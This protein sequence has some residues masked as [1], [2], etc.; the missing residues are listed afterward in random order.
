MSQENPQNI[1]RSWNQ[2]QSFNT[3]P[4]IED[5]L[6]PVDYG[7]IRTLFTHTWREEKLSANLDWDSQA[8]SVYLPESLNVVSSVFLKI[9]LPA[10]G[11]DT[12]KKYP[13]IFALKPLRILSNGVEL[14]TVDCNLFFHDYLE[15][16]SEEGLH[17]VTEAYFG[18]TSA[19]SLEARTIMVPIML[20]NSQYL[21]RTGDNKGHGIFPCFLGN[22]TLELQLTLTP[23]KYV[24]STA[25]SVPASISGACS[26][27]YHQVELSESVLSTYSDLR[28]NY[29]IVNRRFTELTS[30]WTEY[31]TP[32][33]KANINQYQPQGAI[34]EIMVIAVPE[35]TDDSR[36]GTD[37]ILPTSIKVTTDS[38]V[39]KDLNTPNKVKADLWT[40]G[41]CPPADFPSPGRLCFAV[42][43]A[44]ADHVFSG[45]YNMQQASNVDFEFTFDTACRYRVVASAIQRCSIDAKGQ[46]RARLE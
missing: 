26:M 34:T 3:G 43:A 19:L 9:D 6:A 24:A 39:Q 15:S 11:S 17:C 1:I 7:R 33:A 22:S 31:A 18:K 44:H 14:Y 30:G 29:S 20:P 2:V 45:A 42:H 13:G 25:S 23:A 37:Y 40:N 32:N 46:I 36:H 12:D 4:V 5:K 35:N 27:M 28:G 8:F 21:G 10:L 41:F 38:I 16:L